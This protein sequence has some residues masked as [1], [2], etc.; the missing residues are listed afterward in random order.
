M[1]TVMDGR[2]NVYI[3]GGHFS[4]IMF[5][6]ELSNK[7]FTLCVKTADFLVICMHTKFNE[8]VLN[9]KRA[10]LLDYILHLWFFHGLQV[11]LL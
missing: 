8:V 7:V 1:L 11:R 5:M 2:I 6:N 3:I 9:S 10:I 4:C